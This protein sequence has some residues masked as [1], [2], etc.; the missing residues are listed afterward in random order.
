MEVHKHSHPVTHKKKWAERLMEFFMLFLAVF[1]G[2]IAENIREHVVERNKE[3]QYISRFIRDMVIDTTNIKEVIVEDMGWVKQLDTAISISRQRL[4]LTATQDSLIYFLD[5]GARFLGSYTSTDNSLSQL[6]NIG[7][8]RLIEKEHVIDSIAAYQASLSAIEMQNA[9]YIDVLQ[10]FKTFYKEIIDHTLLPAFR[11]TM[12]Q[13]GKIPDKMSL[14]INSDKQK[15][16]I[17]YNNVYYLRN[18][19]NLYCRFMND[20]LQIMKHLITHLK[21]EYNI[22]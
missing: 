7:G 5:Q 20:H 9:Y 17:L 10:G 22:K 16:N 13:N 8:F 3:K 21:N 12:K 11:N 14:F 2:F 19:I 6:R 18:A 1:L 15:I 4:M